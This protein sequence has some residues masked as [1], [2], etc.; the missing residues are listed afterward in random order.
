MADKPIPFSA[1]MVRAILDGRKSM[2]R[3]VLKPQP[4]DAGDCRAVHTGGRTWRLVVLAHAAVGDDWTVPYAPGDLLWVKEAWR[5]ELAFDWTP[6]RDIPAGKPIYYEAAPEETTPDCAGKLRPSR[7]MCRWMSRLTLE[8]TDVRVQRLQEIS[9]NDCLAEG[10]APVA[11]DSAQ[12]GGGV[13]GWGL[14]EHGGLGEPT[15]IAAFRDLWQ[16]IHGENS[17][18]TNPWVVAVSFVRPAPFP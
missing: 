15:A 14:P 7:F 5:A 10:I 11:R 6:P 9:A 12:N 4:Y 3:R 17:W 18:S 16:S 8:V 1:P 13:R 2:T